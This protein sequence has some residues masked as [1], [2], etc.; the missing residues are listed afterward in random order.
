MGVQTTPMTRQHQVVL[1]GTVALLF[2]TTT[3][4]LPLLLCGSRAPGDEVASQPILPGKRFAMQWVSNGEAQRLWLDFVCGG[5]CG[6]PWTGSITMTANGAP[7]LQEALDIDGQEFTYTYSD[8]SNE[9]YEGH[10]LRGL[11]AVPAGTV[12]RLD[13][14]ITPGTVSLMDLWPPGPMRNE[15]ARI[16]RMRVWVA[17]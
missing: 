10:L 9:T 13:G 11:P 5:G 3:V 8:S 16:E 12:V 17:P 6:F 4:A 2:V 14:M 1:L 7:V 15:P